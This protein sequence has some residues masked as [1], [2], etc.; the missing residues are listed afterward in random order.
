M[1]KDS[2]FSH[3]CQTCY[4][5]LKVWDNISLWLLLIFVFP[6][7][8]ILSSFLRT[9]WPFRCLFGKCPVPLPLFNLFFKL[10]CMSSSKILYIITLSH[11][12]FA[13]VFSHLEGC[14]FV[15]LIA[16]CAFCRFG[17]F[18]AKWHPTTVLLPGKFHGWKSLEGCSSWGRWGSDT[19][20]WLHFH[21]QLFL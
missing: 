16:S 6:W 21:F 19:T 14:L 17:K 13:A 15:F 10:S 5:L 1:Y 20:E 12:L 4:Q 2:L 8:V 18:S 3:P 7:L 9:C 11:T